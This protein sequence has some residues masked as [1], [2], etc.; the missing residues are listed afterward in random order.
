MAGETKV[1]E[2]FKIVKYFKGKGISILGNY[3]TEE[4]ANEV[5]DYMNEKIKQITQ[6]V[7]FKVEKI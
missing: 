3:D 2:K 5:C 7:K 6:A 4:R 1:K